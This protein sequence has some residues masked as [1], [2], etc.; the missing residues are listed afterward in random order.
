LLEASYAT[1][2]PLVPLSMGL[3]VAAGMH[4]E[5]D[6]FWTTVLSAEFVC[7]GVLPWLP[8]RPPRKV[9][10]QGDDSVASTRRLNRW[11]LDRF[12]N[13]WNTF[14]SGHVAGSLACGLAITPVLPVA[15]AVV[16]VVAILISVAS[17]VG[18]Y[19]YAADAVAGWAVAI[20]CFVVVRIALA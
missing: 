9:D 3:I 2:Y 12:S 8:T 10:A 14:P 1:V 5:V 18:R 20:G 15:G 11:V 17:V 19:H 4:S 16:I 7:Y 13:H 6:R